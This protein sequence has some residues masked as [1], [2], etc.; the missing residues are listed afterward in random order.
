MMVEIDYDADGTVS[1][2]EWK[3]GGMTTIPLLVLLGLDTVSDTKKLRVCCVDYRVIRPKQHPGYFNFWVSRLMHASNRHPQSYSL[4]LLNELLYSIDICHNSS[5]QNL[6][7]MF[8]PRFDSKIKYLH[9]SA[10]TSV[11]VDPNTA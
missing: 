5:Y 4:P 1:L 9:T 2:S 6:N 11:Q 10:S 7:L 3:R 8:T